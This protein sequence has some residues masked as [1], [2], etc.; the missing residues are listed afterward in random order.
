MATEIFV[1]Y[2]HAD[3]AYL[4]KDSLLGHLQGLKRDGAQFWTDR[5]IPVGI[6]WHK[7]IMAAIDRADIAMVLVS[8]ALLNSEYIQNFEIRSSLVRARDQAM[9]VFP[10]ILS[11]CDWK[12]ES[13]LRQRQFIPT[14]DQTIEEHFAEPPG[15]RKRIFQTITEALRQRVAAVEE[16]K[17]QPVSI[18]AA[19]ESISTSVNTINAMYPQLQSVRSNQPE[20]QHEHSVILEGKG[21]HVVRK[22]RGA[23]TTFT[24]ADLE[25]LTDRQLRHILIFQRELVQSYGKWKKLYGQYRKERPAVTEQTRTALRD[26]VADMEDSLDRVVRFLEDASLDI[27]DHYA[28]FRSAIH[29]EAQLAY[30]MPS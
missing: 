4:D 30:G 12:R 27:E 22:V 15:V 28:I 19:M 21:D 11:P 26:V 18:T 9:F 13:W 7:A 1:S 5:N 2:S 14:N 6:D 20:E 29:A 3:S 17:R 23:V 8:Q 16:T 25:I 24:P 10:I